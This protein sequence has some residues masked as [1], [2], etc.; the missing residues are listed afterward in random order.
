MIGENVGVEVVLTPPNPHHE[1]YKD[2][3]DEHTR[4]YWRTLQSSTEAMAYLKGE[5]KLTDD[6]INE[7]RLGLVPTDEYKT[8]NDIG[9]ISDRI[10]FPI[11][12][13]KDAG[14][15]KCVGMG[16]RTRKDEKPKY[17]NDVNQDGRPAQNNRPAQDANLAGVFVK[18]QLL[19]GYQLAHREIR[20]ANYAIITE[21]YFDV[22]SLHQSGI[23]NTVACMG[24]SLTEAQADALRS[25]TSNLILFMDGD[26]A[27]VMNMVKALPMLFEKGF[28]V[29]MLIA[30]A[31]MDA[32]DICEKMEFAADKLQTYISQK[33][34]P[35]LSV[36]I[37]RTVESYE[38]IVV[39]ERLKAMGTLAPLL[40]KVQNPYERDVYKSKVYKRLD[41]EM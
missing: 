30:E 9:G 18:G 6:T 39:R 12:E 33:A 35:A 20:K 2:A 11:L 37:D 14:I 41:M 28:N 32:A 3:M 23:K 17:I 7:F 38:Q 5:R 34:K 1:A 25:L 19:Y 40:E 27:G 4:R 31:N 36:V 26:S 10:A 15:A 21:G 8:R 22:I 29:M 13:H 24:T 16:Y